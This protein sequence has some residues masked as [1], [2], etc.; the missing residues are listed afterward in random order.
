MECKLHHSS[1][2]TSP[3][4]SLEETMVELERVHTELVMENVEFRRSRAEMDY[5]KV[6]LPRFLDQK[7]NI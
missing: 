1:N 4:S 6:G 5:F 7:E 3:K 2:S